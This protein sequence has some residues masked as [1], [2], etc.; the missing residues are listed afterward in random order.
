[1]LEQSRFSGNF[2]LKLVSQL[3]QLFFSLIDIY[4]EHNDIFVKIH[5]SKQ[6]KSK[7]PAVARV[8]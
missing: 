3:D 6:N 4:T 2:L 8:G 1:M 5:N 7:N